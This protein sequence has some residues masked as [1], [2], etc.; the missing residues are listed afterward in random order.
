MYLCECM[1]VFV[2]FFW[3]ISTRVCVRGGADVCCDVG[4]W[5]CGCE[6]VADEKEVSSCV[7]VCARVFVCM[8]V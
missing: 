6:W 7:F 5:V 4:V 2:V 1:R 8:C 3:V